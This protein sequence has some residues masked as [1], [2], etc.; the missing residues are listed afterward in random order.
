MKHSLENY[1]FWLKVKEEQGGD[2]SKQ[3]SKAVADY[4]SNNYIECRDCDGGDVEE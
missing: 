1:A 3:Q 2:L 4:R